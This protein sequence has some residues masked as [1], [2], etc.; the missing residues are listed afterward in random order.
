LPCI[1][2]ANSI[3]IDAKN[4]LLSS[5]NGRV[6]KEFDFITIDGTSGQVLSGKT[7]LVE[8]AF[9]EGFK[10][11]LDWAKEISV[12]D[13]RANADTPSDAKLARTFGAEGIGLCRT[14]QMFFEKDRLL[15]MRE[16]IFADSNADRK[17]ALDQLL[18]MQRSD[19]E[20]IFQI[21]DGL[22]VCIRLFDPPLHEFLPRERQEMLELAE[23]LDL[24]VSKIAE[25]TKDL[26]EFNPMLGMRGVRLGITLPEIYEMQARAIFE[27]T[28]LAQ[29]ANISIVPEIMIPLVS[30][31]KEVQLIHSYVEKIANEVKSETNHFF[32]YKFGVMVETPRAALRA[33]DIA[34]HSSFMSF[35]TND[36]TQMTY[37]LS[38]DDAGRFMRDYVTKGVFAEDP[39][40]TLD[41]DG[42][43]E[44]LLI[45]RDRGR[46][47]N[48]DLVLSVCGEHGG[49]PNS[50]NFCCKSNFDYV[51]CSPFRVPVAIV[52]AAHYELFK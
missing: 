36:L 12:L 48:T 21:M 23:A 6:F 16:M 51:S 7:E 22:N 38:R 26:S 34:K 30:T 10:T 27:A 15:A 5:S 17:V 9:D 47:E 18:P 42:V 28:V 46:Q 2:G 20:E 19:F 43:G 3:K 1:V 44:L 37:G 14:E 13:V 52:A 49:D 31:R 39:F 45:A 40:H 32:E 41:D 4:R 29:K 35:G 50:I 8:P 33:G 24:P 11:F 25:R